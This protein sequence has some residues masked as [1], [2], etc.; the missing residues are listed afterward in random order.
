MRIYEGLG[1]IRFKRTMLNFVG[2]E[3]ARKMGWLPLNESLDQV[4]DSLKSFIR[5]TKFNELVHTLVMVALMV[6]SIK[7]I[8]EGQ[9]AQGIVVIALNIPFNLYPILLQRYNRRRILDY[10]KARSLR[11]RN[12]SKPH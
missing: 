3:K 4:E 1:I 9:F 8:T 10:L 5:K 2:K 7:L 12:K 6:A 11:K